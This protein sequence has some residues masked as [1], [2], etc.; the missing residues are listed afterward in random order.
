MLLRALLSPYSLF[1]FLKSRDLFLKPILRSNLKV[2]AQ[3]T[4]PAT[5]TLT[6]NIIIQC[7]ARYLCRTHAQREGCFHLA[8][9]FVPSSAN[10]FELLVQLFPH[11]LHFITVTNV[12][13]SVVV[14]VARRLEVKK[15]WHLQVPDY[16]KNKAMTNKYTNVCG[17][18]APNAHYNEDQV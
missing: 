10:L 18:W 12:I 15:S 17:S 3:Y 8:T 4:N 14:S 13:A 1:F 5:Q 9:C 2:L 6:L 16:V 11:H 7:K